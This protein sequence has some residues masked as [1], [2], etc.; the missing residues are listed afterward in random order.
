LKREP[1][2]RLINGRDLIKK[3]KLT[4]GPIF[5]E[6]L[7]AVEDAQVEG[8]IRTKEEALTLVRQTLK[9]SAGH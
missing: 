5:S 9:K 4:P 3:L 1:F 7:N 6:I 2:I 8:R